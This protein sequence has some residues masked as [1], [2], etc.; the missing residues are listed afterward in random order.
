MILTTPFRLI[1]RQLSHLGL[2]D[3]LTFMLI[4]PGGYLKGLFEPVGD[5]APAQVVG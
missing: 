5:A 3:A 4:A 1:T 2:T